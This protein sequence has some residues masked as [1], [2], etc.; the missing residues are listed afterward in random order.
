MNS[1][2]ELSVLKLSIV[3]SPLGGGRLL[4]VVSDGMGRTSQLLG[5]DEMLGLITTLTHPVL[6]VG[7][8]HYP[9]K[10]PQEWEADRIRNEKLAAERDAK[11]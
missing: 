9:M 5:Y 10:L 7:R 8:P 2:D 11:L 3:A 6:R 4:Y 1:C